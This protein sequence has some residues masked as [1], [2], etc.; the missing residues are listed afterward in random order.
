MATSLD[1]AALIDRRKLRP[2]TIR[3]DGLRAVIPM[4]LPHLWPAGN[5]RLR[6][7]V[8]VALAFL[9]AAKLTNIAVPFFLKRVV[10]AVSA[11]GLAVVPLA[12]LAA[13]GAARLGAAA[14]TELR[15]AVFARVGQRAARVTAGAVYTHLFELSLSYHLER[16]TG[17][18]SR[19]IERGV[20]AVSF[21]L[22]TA[23]FSLVPTVLE[24]AL[25]IAILLWRYPPA[26]AAI[27]FGTIA[28]YAVFTV[29]T[30]NWR[31]R[32]RREMNQR[33]NE[34]SG[35]AVDGLIN[36]ETVKAFGNE[37][38]EAARLDRALAAYENAAVR[39]ETSL[40]LLNAG[41]AAIIAIGVSL[42]MWR[43]A[44][45]VVAGSLTVGDVVLVNAFVLQL[46]Q[47]LNF[48]GIMYRELKQSVIDLENI[49]ALRQL[50]SDI[51]DPPDGAA[52]VPGTAT[53]RF[54]N[55]RF[56]YDA[57]RP[58]LE[59]VDFEIP[60]GRK[61]AV[62]GPS[63]AGKS[64]IVRLLFRFYDV[65]GGAV[66]IDGQD[67]RS[68]TQA[69]LRRAIGVVPQD[70]VLFNDTIAANIAYG[71]PGATQAE[72]EAAARTAQI[73]NFIAAL[74]DGYATIV[75]ERGLKLSGG[76][77]Q[78]VAMARVLL[79]D[80]PILVLDEATSAL[81]SRTEQALQEGLARVARGRTTLVIAHRLSTVVDADE[82]VVLDHGRIVERG[83]H[84]TLLARGGL[85]HQMWTRQQESPAEQLL[86]A[87]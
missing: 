42:V 57:R 35:R 71:R 3:P 72:I 19:A 30:T 83:T 69:S 78:R 77:K 46:Y 67:I 48:L 52:L 41:Q 27:V 32:F 2:E 81:D 62:V 34:F 54:A 7:H 5:G 59:A 29:V 64:T 21:L 63:G 20:K 80:P 40:A 17:E 49:S 15:D 58:I 8:V 10:D 11:P 82:I 13:Y 84:A 16:R 56:A 23:L 24:F 25:V 37:G 75:G 9:I 86:P 65:T 1:P 50:R 73:H 36:Y 47:P 43:A 53:V 18:L 70:T 74:P 28:A 6:L 85:Y 68:V 33:D 12:A 51:A 38:Y 87:K 66:L 26:F 55:V 44:A 79:K 39:S 45:G 4:L 60:S 14:F 76:E 22:Q 31:T 61:L